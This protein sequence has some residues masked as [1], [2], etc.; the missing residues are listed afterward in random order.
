MIDLSIHN[1][2]GLSRT[3]LVDDRP[4]SVIVGMNQSGKTSLAQAV[5]YAFCGSVGEIKDPSLLVTQGQSEM[6]VR[7]N[8]P[9]WTLE[10]SLRQ[11][12][13]T[14]GDRCPA[15]KRAGQVLAVTL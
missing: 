7:L 10:R 5:S 4:L 14:F 2:R 1:F 9:G 12:A 3:R 13:K 11:G 8:L 6:R 15:R